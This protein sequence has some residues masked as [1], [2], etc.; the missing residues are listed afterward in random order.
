VALVVLAWTLGLFIDELPRGPARILGLQI[1]MLAGLLVV[2]ITV[3]R[4][5]WRLADPSPAPEPTRFGSWLFAA[6]I[7]VMGRLAHVGLYLLM[8]AVPVA[9]IV[10]QFARGDSL[11]L[12]GIMEIASPWT[13][14]RAFVGKVAEVH[15]AAALLHHWVFGDRTLTRMLPHS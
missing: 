2:V 8:I 7:P 9:G 11:D 5:L 3:F 14:D 13:R 15:A 1:H 6:W 10:L 12:F 4:L